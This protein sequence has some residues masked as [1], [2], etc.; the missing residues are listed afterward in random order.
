MPHPPERVILPHTPPTWVNAGAFFFITICCAERGRNHLCQ[1]KTAK[2]LLEC[3]KFYH[4]KEDWY[5]RIILLMPDHLHVIAAFPLD[6][7]IK[8]FVRKFKI[9]TGQHCGVKWQR[10]FFDHRPRNNNQLDFKLDYIRQNPVRAGLAVRSEDW[11]YRWEPAEAK[12][13][14]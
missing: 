6:S 4:E 9:Y 10:G 12:R 1:P 5:C 13:L 11:E 8:T 7:A 14:T 2:T 3:A